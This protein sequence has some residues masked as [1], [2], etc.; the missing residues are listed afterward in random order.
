MCIFVHKATSS[1]FERRKNF[2]NKKRD[3][4][5]THLVQKCKLGMYG[6]SS[7]NGESSNKNTQITARDQT[8]RV[9]KGSCIRP[10]EKESRRC[11]RSASFVLFPC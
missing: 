10:A 6:R 8:V 5:W 3:C 4:P 7:R 2:G 9:K 11:Q 1:A